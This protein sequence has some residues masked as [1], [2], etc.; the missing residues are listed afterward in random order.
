MGSPFR[1]RNRGTF[2]D[3][4]EEGEFSIDGEKK[5]RGN[6]DGRVIKL[7]SR[8]ASE[9]DELRATENMIGARFTENCLSD[10]QLTVFNE[11]V[12]WAQ[13]AMFSGYDVLTLGGFAGTG[14][15]TLL[16]ALANHFEHSRVAFCSLTGKAVSVL[17]KKFLAQNVLSVE[18]KLSTI[19]ALL[20]TPNVDERTGAIIGWNRK[21]KLDADLV[22]V[23]EG[24]MVTEDILATFREFGVP[25]LAVGDHGQL[26][27]VQGHFNLMETPQLILETVHR[28]AK[29]SPILALTEAVR[30]E[31][32][33]P[34]TYANT[35]EVQFLQKGQ[36][37]EVLQSLYKTPGFKMDD[38]ALL[39]FKNSTRSRLN[40]LAR[41]ARWGK[42]PALPVPGDQV[43]CLR[44]SHE[45]LYNGMRGEITNTGQVTDVHVFGSIAFRDE[46]MGYEGALCRHQFHRYKAFR[47]LG[48]FTGISGYRAFGWQQLGL[49]VDYGYALTVH[50]AQGSEFPFVILYDDYE[51]SHHQDDDPADFYQ[52]WFYTAISRCKKHLVVLR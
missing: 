23:D 16:C 21:P 37:F 13:G 39:C 32:H 26:P 11:I 36:A 8:A 49:L 51:P 29:G 35:L 40:K 25:V 48:E 17:K 41:A 31:G 44:N 6:P 12:A 20:Y 46:G 22:V 27:P 15:T 9:E 10:E 3:A 47:D 7:F 5:L 33:P 4:I 42:E 1:N 28:Q 52:R 50:K 18:H 30:A 2:L 14:K 38:L 34:A 45:G 19:H 24:S 43:I